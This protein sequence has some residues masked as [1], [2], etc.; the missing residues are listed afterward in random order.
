M[1]YF[2]FWRRRTAMRA[3]CPSPAVASTTTATPARFPNVI[4]A[5]DDAR[6]SRALGLQRALDWLLPQTCA[7]CAGPAGAAALCTACQA[8]LP[9]LAEKH[10]PR[11]ADISM[12]G[13]PC[14]HCLR[15]SPHFDR[16]IAPFAYAAPLDTLVQALKYGH[17]LYLA[18]WLGEQVA[19][20]L[21]EKMAAGDPPLIVPMPLHPQRLAARGFNQALEIARP[22]ARRGRLD[23]ATDIARRVRMT[24]AQFD[25]SREERQRNLR[26]AFEC[27][28]DMAGRK[29]IVVDDVMTSGSSANELSRVLKLHGAS[30]V[31]VAVAART[32]NH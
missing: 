24:A 30:E 21:A 23:L 19:A 20:A 12:T 11:C 9:R 10:C 25:L 17:R 2:P 22:L 14:G 7:V 3:D 4:L 6:P 15:E 8:R 18:R 26:N 13:E 28:A 27:R 29:V 32:L 31:W 1:N 5:P 16:V